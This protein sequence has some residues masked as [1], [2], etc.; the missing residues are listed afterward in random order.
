[1]L[2]CHTAEKFHGDECFAVLFANIENGA[3]IGMIQG[4]SGL[5]FAFKTGQSLRI[6]SNLRRQKFER[7]KTMKASVLC[8]VDNAH[9]TTAKFFEHGV[10]RDGATDA[11][12]SAGQ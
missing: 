12:R 11:G 10:M 8:F 3:N 2:Q 4:R 1:M 9:S 7:N 5:R 6:A